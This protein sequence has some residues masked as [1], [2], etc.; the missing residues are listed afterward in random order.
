MEDNNRT[1]FCFV[2]KSVNKSKLDVVVEDRRKDG[3]AAI[4]GGIN[5]EARRSSYATEV[6]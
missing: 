6:Y 5:D 3:V 2:F 4:Y 1:F